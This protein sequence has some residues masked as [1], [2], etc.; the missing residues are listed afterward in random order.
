MKILHYISHFSLPPE[1][2]IYDLINNLEDKDIDNYIL[3][4]HRIAEDTRPFSKVK[5]TNENVFL[6]KKIYYKLF[7]PWVIRNQEGVL[8]YIK[9]VQPHVIHAHF[10]PNGIKIYQLLKKYN[11]NIPLI[12]S[13][14]GTDTTMYPL[15]YKQYRN[16]IRSLSLDQNI[17]FTFP[18]NFLKQEFQKNVGVGKNDNQIV[19][20][21]S[22]SKNFNIRKIEYFDGKR[23][24]KLVSIGRLI[25]VKGFKYLIKAVKILEDLSSDFELIIIG[26]GVERQNLAKLIKKNNLE[27]KVK[28]IGFVKHNEVSK[29]LYESDIY[30]Q[31]S[32]VDDNTNQT[33]SFGVSVIEAIVT[34]L[35]VIVT[36]VGGLPDTVLGGHQEFAKIVPSKNPEAIVK[37][38]LEMM[39]NCKDNINFRKNIEE[40]Y[41]QVH[42]IETT[43]QMYNRQKEKNVQ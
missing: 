4:H 24:L 13:M 25:E 28:L 23:T 32:I 34:G 26:D 38:I 6:L 11:I 19:L 37:S 14:H 5:V 16:D 1:T 39:K 20:P 15:K 40:T 31:P 30:I 29:L 42:Q 27:N 12:I 3:T 43:L 22:Y 35:P 8:A 33:E 36:N 2:F 10:G 17:I 21:N 41:S 7:K 9:E 18:S